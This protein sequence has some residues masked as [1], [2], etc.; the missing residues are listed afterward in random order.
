MKACFIKA[1]SGSGPGFGLRI[2]AAIKGTSRHKVTKMAIC[3]G[4]LFFVLLFAVGVVEL[5]VCDC[6][7]SAYSMFS[8]KIKS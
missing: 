3:A 4:V 6:K 7:Y 8:G 2:R 1:Y 5:S